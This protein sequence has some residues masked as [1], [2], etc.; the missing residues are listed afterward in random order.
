MSGAAVVLGGAAAYTAV[1]GSEVA[2]VPV[3]L[4]AAGVTAGAALLPDLDCPSSTV[5]RSCGPVTKVLSELVDTASLGIYRLTAGPKDSP[6]E[7]GHRTFTHT[8]LAAVLAGLGVTALCGAF[9]KPAV[10]GV[11]AFTLMFAIRG[12][13][14]DWAKKEGWL[15]VLGVTAACT[16]AAWWTL[17]TD[18]TSYAFLG[19]CVTLGMILHD[20]GDAITRAGVPLLAP[21]PY[22]GKR[23]WEFTL[24]PLAIRAGGVVEAAVLLPALSAA[25]ILG[26]VHLLDPSILPAIL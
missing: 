23:W 11:L 1:T 9:G 21:V 13:M 10:L 19:V 14:A 17:P 25:A 22:N 3:L 7:G 20:L 2:P 24:G 12:L 18:G 6:R 26:L 15:A 5:A 4:T 8:I 16:A